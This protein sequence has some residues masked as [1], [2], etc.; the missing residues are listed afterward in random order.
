MVRSV[1]DVPR[2]QSSSWFAG[3]EIVARAQA[4][5]NSGAGQC[6]AI[7]RTLG[8][9]PVQDG[10][11]MILRRSTICSFSCRVT[12]KDGRLRL[13]SA[14]MQ[15]TTTMF[16]RSMSASRAIW[17]GPSMPT[18]TTCAAWRGRMRRTAR[19][20]QLQPLS[21]GLG[22]PGKAQHVADAG[23]GGRFAKRPHHRDQ[24]HACD[25][26]AA[27]EPSGSGQQRPCVEDHAM[28][29]GPAA[30]GR[31]RQSWYFEQIM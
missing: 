14:V 12:C 1:N 6:P 30:G 8:S 20:T 28:P 25:R 2:G 23:G 9:S 3:L 31:T 21:S 5:V 7:Q 29:D 11:A 10:H 22:G 4:E 16:G 19:A 18:S 17:P 15:V 26:R 27:I 24:R 13:C